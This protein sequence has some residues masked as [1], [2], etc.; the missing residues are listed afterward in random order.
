MWV[1]RRIPIFL[2]QKISE[3]IEEA[4]SEDRIKA[5]QRLHPEIGKHGWWA[6]TKAVW[7][8][9]DSPL[10]RLQTCRDGSSSKCSQVTEVISGRPVLDRTPCT[11][12]VFQKRFFQ[13]EGACL[14]DISKLLPVFCRSVFQRDPVDPCVRCELGLL[15]R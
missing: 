7:N 14:A 1:E 2:L 10:D 5:V 12:P 15:S 8:F 3:Q 13:K 11:A 4:V 6:R 9:M